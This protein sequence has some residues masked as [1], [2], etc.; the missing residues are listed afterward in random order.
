MRMIGI[1]LNHYL[2]PPPSSCHKIGDLVLRALY[3]FKICTAK[4]YGNM[5][6]FV[7]YPNV[8]YFLLTPTSSISHQVALL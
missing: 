5:F 7:L 6:L 8:A 4:L 2:M 3:F 1:I